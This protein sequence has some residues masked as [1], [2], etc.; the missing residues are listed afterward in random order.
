MKPLKGY[1]NV[2]DQ[3]IRRPCEVEDCTRTAEIPTRF[4][5]ESREFKGWR[6][7]QHAYKY[8]SKGGK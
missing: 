3:F 4:D 2:T 7:W 8:F 6:C 1:K 5:S